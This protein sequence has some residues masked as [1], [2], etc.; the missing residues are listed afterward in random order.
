MRLPVFE[1]HS[2]NTICNRK[3]LK[4]LIQRPQQNEKYLI[5]QTSNYENGEKQI[6]GYYRV[7]LEFYYETKMWDNYGFV[8][9]IE[10]SDVHLIKKGELVYSGNR[11]P[12]YASTFHGD[13]NRYWESKLN[14]LIND[15]S[16]RPNIAPTYKSET[17]RL[18]SLFKNPEKL[19][20][21]R[22]KCMVCTSKKMCTFFRRNRIY[23]RF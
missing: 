16:S 18:I 8:W 12:R 1:D 3:G 6:V 4:A 2:Y 14:E 13:Q 9:G 5:F 23:R 19:K 21:W 15:I 22:Q 17:N 20:E 10:G 11:I 7:G